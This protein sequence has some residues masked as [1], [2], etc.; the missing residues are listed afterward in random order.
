MIGGIELYPWDV[1]V[2]DVWPGLS[3]VDVWLILGLRLA[4]GRVVVCASG[5]VAESC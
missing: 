3:T 1:L 4:G 2:E 5:F